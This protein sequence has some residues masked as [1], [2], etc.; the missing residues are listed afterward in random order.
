MCI[1]TLLATRYSAALS[2]KTAVFDA[3]ILRQ[4]YDWCR[5]NPTLPIDLAL[6]SKFGR[7]L[8][9]SSP[10]LYVNPSNCFS[11]HWARLLLR[12]DHWQQ[13]QKVTSSSKTQ[14]LIIETYIPFGASPAAYNGATIVHTPA[15]LSGMF[16]HYT[17][18]F[19][20]FL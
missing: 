14:K 1:C 20:L 9:E 5:Q 10:Q 6:V 2:S 4:C 11:T 7:D 19:Y 17:L 15:T 12:K 13:F 8:R 3:E 16:E 18:L